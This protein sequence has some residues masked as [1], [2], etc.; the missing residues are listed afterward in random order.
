MLISY[1]TLKYRVLVMK[2][3][4][5]CFNMASPSDL[6]YVLKKRLDSS[7]RTWEGRGLELGDSSYLITTWPR[8]RGTAWSHDRM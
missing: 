1:D 5:E 2:R 4:N 8:D 6:I 7:Q 3:W